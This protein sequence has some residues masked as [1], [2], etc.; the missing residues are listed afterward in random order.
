MV[1]FMEAIGLF[2]R[3]YVD[4][5]GRSQRSEYWWFQLFYV[6]SLILLA[7]PLFSGGTNLETDDL[8]SLGLASVVALVVFVLGNAI[9]Q[10]ALA[11]RRF[12]DLG[13]TGWLV[14]VF[15][16]GGVIP[17]IGTLVSIGQL[18]WFA[19]RGTQ[20]PNAYGPDPLQ[21]SQADIFS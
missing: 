2:Y 4:F 12:H 20:G 18:I 6:L 19:M 3:R 15:A 16:I 9:G 7:I 8:S 21:G 17:L 11:V 5:Q 10:I 14:L 1:S 13:Q